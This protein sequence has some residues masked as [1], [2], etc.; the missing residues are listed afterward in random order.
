MGCEPFKTYLMLASRCG[1]KN[2][3]TR[4]TATCGAS[5]PQIRNDQASPNQSPEPTDMALAYSEANSALFG[6]FS[7]NSR[8]NLCARAV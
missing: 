7:F 1:P 2:N 8:N 6:Y 3:R 5:A 4:L